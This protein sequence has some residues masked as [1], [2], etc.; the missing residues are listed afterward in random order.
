MELGR[1]LSVFKT[2]IPM[3]VGLIPLAQMQLAMWKID[4]MAK[5]VPL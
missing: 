5:T 2:N 3:N 1:D 4:K